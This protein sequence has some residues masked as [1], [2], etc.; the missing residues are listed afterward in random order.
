VYQA[1][2][3]KMKDKGF[4]SEEIEVSSL[5][6]NR[7]DVHHI[8]P[9]NYLKK[10]GLSK[11][12]YNQIA[13]YVIAQSEINIAI[14]DKP[15]ADYFLMLLEQVEGGKKRFG[16]ITDK[17]LLIANLKEHCVPLDIF[18]SLADDYDQFLVERRKLMALK[19]KE[20]FNSL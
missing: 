16:G 2:Q 6:V 12:R 5:L 11:G 20:Y 3:V 17:D 13:N 4:L 10:Q 7:S 15:P 19:I 14:G 8:F 9:R 1:A 18:N